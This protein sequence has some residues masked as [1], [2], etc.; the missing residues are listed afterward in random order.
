MKVVLDTNVLLAILPKKSPYRIAWDK[1]LDGSYE[2]AVTTPILLEYFEI[3]SQKTSKTV[4]ENVLK[5]LVE[6]PN[7]EMKHIYYHFSFLSDPDDNK[8]VDCAFSANTK[9]IVSNDKH[10]N[11]LKEIQ[12]PKIDVINVQ[13]FVEELRLS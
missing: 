7:V 13:N 9:F 8:F 10:F 3:L 11:I 12:F 5:L 6:L 1:L 4:A 2:I